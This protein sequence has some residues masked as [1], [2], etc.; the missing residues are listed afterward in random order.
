M[1]VEIEELKAK[2]AAMEREAA[3]MRRGHAVIRSR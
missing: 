1:K 2:L 3:N